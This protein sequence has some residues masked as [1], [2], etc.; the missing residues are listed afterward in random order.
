MTQKSFKNK[1][2]VIPFL[3]LFS[4]H[5]IITYMN[6]TIKCKL[7]PTIR[8]VKTLDK[9][10]KKCL[11]AL[12]YIS[13]IAWNKKCFNRVALHHLTYYKIKS[14][15]KFSSQICCAIKDKVAFSYRT[16]KK[17]EH[18]FKQS[19]LPLNFNRTIT[20]KSPEIASISTLSGRQKIP[21][22]LGDYQRKMLSKTIKFCDSE[23]IKRDKKFYLN[24]T[25]E[26][27][28][29]PLKKTKDILGVDLGIKNIAV[30]SNGQKFTGEQIQSV[31][32]RYGALRK[33]LQSKGTCSAKR[34]LKKM[35]GREKRFQKDINH[36]ISK[37][38]VQF[39]K[40]SDSAIAL[41]D[42][43]N[44]QK[45]AKQRRKYRGTFHRWAFFQ[46]RQFISYKAQ[47]IGIPII[48]VNPAYTSQTCSS[49]GNLGIRN[50]IQF[51]CP[52][53]KFQ[54]DSDY[55]ASINIQRVAVNQPIVASVLTVKGVNAQLRPSL[56]TSSVH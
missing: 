24:I 1:E 28:D 32:E 27:S 9:T 19:I 50:G 39:A 30:C 53:C 29:E 2:R 14:K 26:I 23:L 33:S 34:H 13:K 25:I 10:L 37:Q 48:I 22:A 52:F 11:E 49:C 45:T 41:E 21:L 8:Q 4:L 56:V 17:K 36:Q 55:N 38:I 3:D 7:N 12:N 43:R 44:I 15:F 16:D 51:F 40:E 6:I 18:I 42:L 20:F 46:L 31:R 54:T 35:S 47:M 5:A